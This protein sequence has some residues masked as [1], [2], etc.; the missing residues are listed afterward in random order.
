M[1]NSSG[2]FILFENSYLNKLEDDDFR[3]GKVG[4]NAKILK[5]SFF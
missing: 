3:K 4:T 2:K 1:S 5:K